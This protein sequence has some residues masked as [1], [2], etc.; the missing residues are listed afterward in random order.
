MGLSGLQSGRPQTISILAASVDGKL[1]D[2]RRSPARFGSAADQQRL[3][4][5]VAAADAVLFG[6]G[7]LRAYGTTLP[8]RE[9]ALLAARQQTGRPAQPIQIVC[10]RTAALDPDWR[11]FRQPVPRWLLTTAAG[12]ERWQGRA[13]FARAIAAPDCSERASFD[14]PAVLAELAALGIE[15]LAVL[16]GGTLVAALLAADAIDELYLTLCPLVLGGT[17]APTLCAGAGWPEAIAPR[18]RLL[19]AEP[20]GDEVFLHYRVLPS[21][22]R[23]D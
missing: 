6:A 17:T 3:E 11:F 1:A 4:Q 19:S 12:V 5:Q 20:V 7:T 15:R 10:S 21:A 22:P 2:A 18:L 9:P 13:E 8:V 14:W 23:G 16:G